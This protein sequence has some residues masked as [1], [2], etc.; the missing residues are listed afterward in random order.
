MN[1]FLLILAGIILLILLILFSPV[2]IKVVYDGKPKLRVGLIFPV[3]GIP[4]AEPKTDDP[5]KLRKLEKKQKKKEAKKQKKAEKKKIK[6]EKKKAKKPASQTEE[7]PKKQNLVLK[8]IKEEG[9]EG[10]IELLKQIADILKYA[11]KKITD[12]L[13]ISKMDLKIALGG[14]DAAKIALNYG[15]IGSAVYPSVAFIQQHVKK[16]RHK[17]TILPAF[18]QE[19][20]KISLVLIIKIRPFFVISAAMGSAVKAFRIFFKKSGK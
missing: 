10:L 14:E 3:F 2:V 19:E 4:I 6:E 16:C 5:K 9:L 15:R 11:V 20:M 1:V 12:H 18:A 7:Q 17:E 13:I 8:K